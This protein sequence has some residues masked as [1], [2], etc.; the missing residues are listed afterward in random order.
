M[1]RHRVLSAIVLLP[2]VL[3]LARL[4]DIPWSLAVLVVG[5]LGWREMTNLLQRNH[6]AVD[7]LLGLVFIIA[8]VVEAYARSQ[9]LIT[10]DLLRPL[11][12]GLLIFSLTWALYDRSE[13]PTVTWAI[14]V[15]GALYMGFLLSHFVSLRLK[16]QGFSWLLLALALTWINDSMAYFVGSAWGRH[17]L[18]PRV[19][20]KKTWEGLF[21]GLVSTLVG[22]GLLAHY[23]VNVPTWS[24]VLLGLL[25][26]IAATF[27][28][29][30][31]SLLKRMAQLKDS[32]NLIPGH[33]GI[34]DRLDSLMFTVPIVTYFAV[35]MTSL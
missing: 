5:I 18:W 21:G 12:T 20:P 10:I 3:V 25:I 22:G 24:G 14:N 29:L 26:A 17:K 8:C 11:L 2:I 35:I 31:V 34:L 1:L 4:G 30:A 16:P 32:S 23:L 28:D 27:G 33:G 13:H 6:F 19:S 7:R 15:A 9:E